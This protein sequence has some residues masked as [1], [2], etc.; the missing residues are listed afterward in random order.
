MNER[1]EPAEGTKAIRA[2]GTLLHPK[3][4]GLL[5]SLRRKSVTWASPFTRVD[6]DATARMPEA[7]SERLTSLYGRRQAFLS[8]LEAGAHL[9]VLAASCSLSNLG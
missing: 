8:E 6:S 4:S 3:E 7:V 1:W 2:F 5:Q 9:C